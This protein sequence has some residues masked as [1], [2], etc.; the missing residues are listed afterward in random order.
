MQSQKVENTNFNPLLTSPDLRGR[1]KKRA[2]LQRILP[3]EGHAC[4]A[5]GR[6]DS[7]GVDTSLFAS[8]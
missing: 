3:Q 2:C 8:R 1:K 5:K 6:G 4:V 7:E